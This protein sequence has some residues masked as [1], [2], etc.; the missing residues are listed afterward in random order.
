[1]NSMGKGIYNHK[2]LSEAHKEAIRRALKG[3]TWSRG[4]NLGNKNAYGKTRGSNNGNWKGGSLTHA[5]GREA[6]A[7]RPR[8]THCEVCYKTGLT[9]FDHCHKTQKFRGWLCR[10]C[11][12]VLGM[13]KDNPTLLRNLAI[14]LENQEAASRPVNITSSLLNPYGFQSNHSPQEN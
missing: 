4:K 14:Y 9:D 11:N 8:S 5:S 7:G 3:N 10:S 1:M 13:V 2:P 6:R 12:L